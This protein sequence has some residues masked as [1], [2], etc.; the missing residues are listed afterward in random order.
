MA[1]NMVVPKGKDGQALVPIHEQLPDHMREDQGG[2]SM[3]LLKQYIVP[4]R[5]KIVQPQA[6]A[7]FSE[8][9]KEADLVVM[10]VLKRLWGGYDHQSQA[11]AFHFVPILF[12]PEWV[13]W[14]P[15]GSNLP[16]IRDRSFK[17]TSEIALKARN[18]ETRQEPCKEY[19]KHPDDKD[20]YVKHQEHLNYLVLV[21]GDGEF[22]DLPLIMSFSSGEHRSG[23]NFNALVQ[24]RRTKALYGCQ[25]SATVR[26]RENK[27]GKWY[28]I[29]VDNPAED[30]GVTPF[31]MDR[32]RYDQLKRLHEEYAGYMS[33]DLIQTQYDDDGAVDGTAVPTPASAE[34]R[35]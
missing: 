18:P 34:E 29:D 9:F 1:K 23:T 35:F 16:A 25:F 8:L 15:Y 28:G 17:K 22:S 13:S 11:P 30:S 14:N 2:G 20:A 4:P 7:P 6:K 5:I 10:P 3:D 21:L 32:D 27:V 12:W 26:R 31:V 19:P 24:S 33:A